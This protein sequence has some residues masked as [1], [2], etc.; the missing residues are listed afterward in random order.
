MF[1]LQLTIPRP[2]SESWA[3]MTPTATGRHCA[4]CQKTVV[5]FTQLT[6]A[7]ILAHLA[8]TGQGEACGRFRAGQLGRPLQPLTLAGPSRWRTWL[9]A[10]VAVWGLRETA[11]VAAQAQAPVEQHN[12]GPVP[13]QLQIERRPDYEGQPAARVVLRG[14]VLDSVTREGLPGV[15]V[16]L[17]GTTMGTATSAEGRFELIVPAAYVVDGM[18][19][20]K[21]NSLL[22]ERKE[23]SVSSTSAAELTFLLKPAEVVLNG[24]VMVMPS[25][26]RRVPPAPWHPRRFYHWTKYWLTRPFR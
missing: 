19:A 22:Y 11:G 1:R 6:D 3:A 4:A 17:H 5:D 10:A 16:I 13:E 14:V 15:S 21:I 24:G 20:L 8:R 12:A 2:C 9:V 26:A 7:E 23:C 25:Y 18:V